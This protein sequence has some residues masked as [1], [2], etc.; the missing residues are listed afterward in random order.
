M[1]E[2]VRLLKATSK[3]KLQC[4]L[5]GMVALWKRRKLFRILK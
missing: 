2:K 5:S 4:C 3:S 1:L